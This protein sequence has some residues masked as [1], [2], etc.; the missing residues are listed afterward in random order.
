YGDANGDKKFDIQDASAIQKYIA[1]IYTGFD[2]V[3]L[4]GK[5]EYNGIYDF[6]IDGK[7]NINDATALQKYLAKLN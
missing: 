1:K 5:F 2:D 6:N 3:L 7:I 4:S